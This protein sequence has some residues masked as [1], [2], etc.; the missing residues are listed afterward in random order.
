MG[1]STCNVALGRPLRLPCG[2]WSHRLGL[3]SVRTV[4]G[5]EPS[6]LG[7]KVLSQGTQMSSRLAQATGGWVGESS[8]S[9]ALPRGPSTTQSLRP[10]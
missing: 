10:N 6:R 4:E 2:E 9:A 3:M 1:T 7:G 5:Q 8:S